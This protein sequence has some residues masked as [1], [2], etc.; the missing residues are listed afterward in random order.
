MSINSFQPDWIQWDGVVRNHVSEN[1]ENNIPLHFEESRSAPILTNPEDY[2]MTVGRFQTDSF[3]LPTLFFQVKNNQNNPL[4][5][6]YG[7]TLEYELG[8]IPVAYTPLENLIWETQHVSEQIPPAPS[9]NSDGRQTFCKYYYCMDPPHFLK[10][11]NEALARSMVNLKALIPGVFDTVE[12]PFLAW[13]GDSQ[14]ATIYA[15]E[16]HFQ[17]VTNGH[18][19][20]YFNR[21]LYALF[22]SFSWKRHSLANTESRQYQL[23]LEGFQGANITT[24]QNHGIDALIFSKQTTSCLAQW[25]PVSSIIFTSS[26]LPIQSQFM[27][28]PQVYEDGFQV[29]LRNA[30]GNFAPILTDFQ[31]SIDAYKPDLLL[32]PTQYRWIHLYGTTPITRIEFSAF[33]KDKTGE[34][35]ALELAS[36]ASASIKLYFRKKKK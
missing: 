31:I 22:N 9:E 1:H 24:L 8:G 34:L 3:S 13:N 16:S 28:T 5:G 30:H 11:L 36:S 12:Q 35:R 4:L 17:T 26:S 18:I 33:F 14:K 23:L 32:N 6:I 20:I 2:E 10:L 27:S 21:N 25:T 29:H 15:R 7:V 19:N